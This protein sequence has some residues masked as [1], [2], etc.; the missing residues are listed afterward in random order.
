MPRKKRTSKKSLL[1]KK[2]SSGPSKA[3]TKIHGLSSSWALLKRSTVFWWRHRSR[4][5]W[6]SGLYFVSSFLLARGA[7][8][9]TIDEIR[10]QVSGDADEGFFDTVTTAGVALGSDSQANTSA[11][12]YQL[13]LFVVFSLATIWMIRRLMASQSFRIRDTFYKGMYPLIP[14][15]AILVLI[16]IQ[17]LPFFIGGLIYSFVTIGGVAFGFLEQIPF[18]I[19]W[20]LLSAGTGYLLAGSVMTLY[21][22]TLP[23]MYPLQALRAVRKRAIYRRW[24][25]LARILIISLVL[26]VLFSVAFIAIVGFIPSVTFVSIDFLWALIVPFLHVYLFHLYR[27]LV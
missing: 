27:E 2:S 23:D 10:Q 8:I 1:K 18:L 3:L 15:A 11:S 17:T 16:V 26:A 21:A 13:I 19:L 25:I 12:A 9:T 4:F 22:V 14:F 6:I 24:H 20:I 7:E 5:L